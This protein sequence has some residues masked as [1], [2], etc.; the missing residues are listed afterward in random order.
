[1]SKISKINKIN[2][3]TFSILNKIK[4][5]IN[6]SFNSS[7]KESGNNSKIENSLNDCKEKIK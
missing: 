6:P 5:V 7:N 2:L 1:M 3:K 4:G